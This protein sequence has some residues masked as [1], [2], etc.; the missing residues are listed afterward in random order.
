VQAVA[1]AEPVSDTNGTPPE[2]P[3]NGN[4]KRPASKVGPLATSKDNA[5]VACVWENEIT[6]GGETFKVHNV[7][8]EC[9]YRD[10]SGEW[11]TGKSFRGS[12]LHALLYCLGRCAD[13]I[14][15]ARDPQNDCPF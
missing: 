3:A 8:I 10:G 15:A 11:K 12:Q 1:P 9:R 2:Q 6:A 5:V 14:F 13:F 7:T 4:G